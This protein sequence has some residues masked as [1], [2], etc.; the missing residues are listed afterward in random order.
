MRWPVN[1][2][3][4]RKVQEALR[5]KVTI[6][7]IRTRPSFIAGVDAAYYGEMVIGVASLYKYPEIIPI[8]DSHVIEESLFPYVPGYLS[9]REGPSLIHAIE[10]LKIKPELIIFDGQGIAHPKGMGIASHIGALLDISAIGC[11]KSRLV[12]DYEVPGPNRGDWSPLSFRETVVGAVLRTKDDVRPLFVSPGHR[13][14][15]SSSMEIV[16]G[17]ATRYRMP[18]P[19]RRADAIS[20]RVRR[21]LTE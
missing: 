5:N 15:L 4:A 14:D 6:A 10:I 1:I 13:I 7:P 9:F 16:L 3:E 17:S 21:D 18:E 8:E 2:S 11:A 12:G 20:R 19:L